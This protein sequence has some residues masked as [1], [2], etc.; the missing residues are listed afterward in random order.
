MLPDWAVTALQAA[1][2]LFSALLFL[3]FCFQGS[4]GW[5][6]RRRRLAGVPLDFSLVKRHR[7]L[8]PVLAA[9]LPFGYLAGLLTAYLHKGRWLPFPGHF[10]TGTLLL[11]V[12]LSLFLVSRQIRGAQSPWRTPHFA[13]GVLLLCTFLVQVY[14]G[15]DV[16]L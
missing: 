13:L 5:R 12:V 4:L 9:L 10:A 11:A 6:N 16:L 7:A 1:H 2:A 3:A 15:L 14:L 8:G